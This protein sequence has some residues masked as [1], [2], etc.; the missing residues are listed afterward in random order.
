MSAVGGHRPPLQK[1]LAALSNESYFNLRED[2]DEISERDQ[3]G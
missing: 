2:V 3:S 1:H